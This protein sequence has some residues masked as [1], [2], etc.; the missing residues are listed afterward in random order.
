MPERANFRLRSIDLFLGQMRESIALSREILREPV[1]DTFLG[2]KTQEPFPKEG[3][4]R[5]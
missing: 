1:P 5:T 2:R 3:E 4:E